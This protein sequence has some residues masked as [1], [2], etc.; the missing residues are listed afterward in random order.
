M[1]DIVPHNTDKVCDTHEYYSLVAVL[2]QFFFVCEQTEAE[3][4]IYRQGVVCVMHT[5][6]LFL[7]SRR[8]ACWLGV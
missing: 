3:T 1:V 4:F 5:D 2:L 8:E 6:T 7:I